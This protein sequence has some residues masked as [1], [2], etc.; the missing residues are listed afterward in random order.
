MSKQQVSIF[1]GKIEEQFSNVNKTLE[2]I[3]IT[4]QQKQSP[5]LPEK[6]DAPNPLGH[7]RC[8]SH[9]L[10]GGF[11]DPEIRNLIILMR[12][13]GEQFTDI[14]E[15]I[16]AKHPNNPEKHV[17]RSSIQRF[18]ESARKGRLRE[19]GINTNLDQNKEG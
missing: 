7:K 6:A 16:R 9:K 15:C 3:L 11:R 19:Y 4:L 13:Q 10:I 1:M 8:R 5:I 2:K 17:S 14:A 12:K 18:C